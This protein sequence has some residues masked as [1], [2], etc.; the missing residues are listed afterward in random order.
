M[1]NELEMRLPIALTALGGSAE[2]LLHARTGNRYVPLTLLQGTPF[3]TFLG[4]GLLLLMVDGIHLTT[5]LALWRRA[6]LAGDLA[7]LS[8]GAISVWIVA[9][10]KSA[11][12][13]PQ[14][15]DAQYLRV[16]HQCA[17]IQRRLRS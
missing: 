11:S 2:L 13:A 5:T 16:E 8:S 1:R 15:G 12:L 7:I 4:P 9:S 3:T 17:Q 14:G 10:E 6:P